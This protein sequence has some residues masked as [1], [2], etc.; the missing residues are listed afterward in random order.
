LRAFFLLFIPA[1]R[2]HGGGPD[3]KIN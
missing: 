2:L 3:G 1:A